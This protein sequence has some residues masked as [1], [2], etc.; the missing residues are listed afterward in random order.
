MDI[1]PPEHATN[2]K[3]PED[4]EN[5]P[6]AQQSV[7]AT[8]IEQEKSRRSSGKG[9]RSVRD[10]KYPDIKPIMLR[11]R[12]KGQK[13]IGTAIHKNLIRHY[14]DPFEGQLRTTQRIVCELNKELDKEDKE[15]KQRIKQPD[16][17]FPEIFIPQDHHPG[18]VAQ[19]DCTGLANLRITIG[20]MPFKGKI[21]TFKLMCSK[22]IYASIVSGET[23]IE[24]LESWPET[25][26]IM[27]RGYTPGNQG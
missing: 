1:I 5:A 27:A 24:V 26:R 2:A 6:A 4:G 8:A 21:F 22:W 17:P 13:T 10:H 3:E 18:E 25:D 11:N 7:K 12:E 19:L 23:D 14:G 16:Q 20:G 15:H 9:Q